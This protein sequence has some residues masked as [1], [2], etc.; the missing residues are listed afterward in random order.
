MSA[1]GKKDDIAV[2]KKVEGICN[3][4]MEY[5]GVCVLYWLSRWWQRRKQ[6]FLWVGCCWILVLT[7]SYHSLLEQLDTVYIF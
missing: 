3:R 1:L 2:G 7:L 6:L 4:V 5:K